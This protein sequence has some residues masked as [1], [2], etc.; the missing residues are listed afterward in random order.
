MLGF[1]GDDSGAV[2]IFE[3]AQPI[4]ADVPLPPRRDASSDAPLKPQA[5]LSG[6]RLQVAARASVSK[7]APATRG[8]DPAMS[9]TVQ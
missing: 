3:P 5:A 2:R 8:L 9:A 4:P 7:A 6:P 1:S